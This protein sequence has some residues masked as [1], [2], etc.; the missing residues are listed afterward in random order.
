MPIIRIIIALAL[1]CLAVPAFAQ[2]DKMNFKNRQAVIINN[3]V[4]LLELSGFRFENSYNQSRFRLITNLKWTNVSSKPISA[5][6]VVIM[7]Y[8]PFN[9]PILS[10]G[11]WLI[12]GKD[13]GDWNSLMP[14]ETSGDGLIAYDDEPI[15]TS[16]VYVRAIRFEEG[17]VWMADTKQVEQSIRS[18]LPVLKDL[19]NINPS[20]EKDK[21]P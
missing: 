11:R 18:K 2:A 10:G 14:K 9:R 4:G 1:V 5:F 8:D 15:M 13:S 16:I 3:A 17:T 6:E 12:T 19:G 21:K 20:M 7:R